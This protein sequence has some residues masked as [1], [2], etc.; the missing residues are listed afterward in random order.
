MALE[1]VAEDLRDGNYIGED[2]HKQLAAEVVETA[3]RVR[4]L[5]E[6]VKNVVRSAR[7]KL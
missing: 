7:K 4:E 5:S 2:E 1:S 3:V 6:E